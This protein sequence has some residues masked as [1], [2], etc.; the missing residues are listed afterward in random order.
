MSEKRKK[1]TPWTSRASRRWNNL[2]KQ[3]RIPHQ[4]SQRKRSSTPPPPFNMH[5]DVPKNIKPRSFSKTIQRRPPSLDRRRPKGLCL[6]MSLLGS[7]DDDD[8][9]REEKTAVDVG[10]NDVAM[11]LPHL[12]IS[13]PDRLKHVQTSRSRYHTCYQ[14]LQNGAF[15]FYH[16]H[17]SNTNQQVHRAQSSDSSR[18]HVLDLKLNDSSSSDVSC[19]ST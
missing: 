14:L 11:V 19:S 6:D 18:F 7:E 17:Y 8:M 3:P 15:R 5:S 10:M 9:I 2:R 16:F 1:D 12:F 13:G 4:S